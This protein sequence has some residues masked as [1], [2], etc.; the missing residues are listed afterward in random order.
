MGTRNQQREKKMFIS[1][2]SFEAFDISL[3]TESG[4]YICSQGIAENFSLAPFQNIWS[5]ERE[6]Y[7]M[8]LPEKSAPF[9]IKMP[10]DEFGHYS[11][12]EVAQIA[13]DKLNK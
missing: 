12:I 1:F 8:V 7:A 13:A 4:H 3:D 9:S 10:T 6:M 5:N 11:I 2:G